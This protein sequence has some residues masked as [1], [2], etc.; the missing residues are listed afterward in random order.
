MVA[1]H[2]NGVFAAQ[3][4]A[5]SVNLVHA[6]PG[7]KIGILNRRAAANASIVEQNIQPAHVFMRGAQSLLPLRF[8][9]NIQPIG[10]TLPGIK[11]I[12]LIGDDLGALGIDI[13]NRDLGALFSQHERGGTAQAGGPSGYKSHF[14]GYSHIS[15]SFFRLYYSDRSKNLRMAALFSSDPASRAYCS[16]SMK[17]AA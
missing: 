13:R 9:C 11:C 7:F 3:K 15:V 5:V 6:L 10:V 1:H 14:S 16:R 8:I 4:H 12:N 17:D 2:R